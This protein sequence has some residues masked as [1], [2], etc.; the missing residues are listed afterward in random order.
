MQRV[1]GGWA[2]RMPNEPSKPGCLGPHVAFGKCVFDGR[3]FSVK[4]R[5]T[6]VLA[7]TNEP[8]SEEKGA[9]YEKAPVGRQKGRAEAQRR[10]GN[11]GM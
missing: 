4:K 7:L 3:K 1:H 2:K 5:Y 8:K 6:E 9:E 11:P 10:W